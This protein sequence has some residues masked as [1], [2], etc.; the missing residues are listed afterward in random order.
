MALYGGV[1]PK[2]SFRTIEPQSQPNLS[3]T[4]VVA[5]ISILELSIGFIVL[6]IVPIVDVQFITVITTMLLVF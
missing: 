5:S 4:V 3:I 2:Q 6:M 1:V